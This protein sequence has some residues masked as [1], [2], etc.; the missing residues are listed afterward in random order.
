MSDE[1]SKHFSLRQPTRDDRGWLIN[2][3][4]PH[5]N[6]PWWAP[7]LAAIP[8]LFGAILVRTLM[9]IIV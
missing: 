3:L 7:P 9:Q 8:A 1:Q 2:P 6:M 4:G 5:G